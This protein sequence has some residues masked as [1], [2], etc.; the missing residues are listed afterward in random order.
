MTPDTESPDR[1]TMAVDVACVGFG[2]AT[3]G[4]LTRLSRRL[5]DPALPPLE[6]AAAPGM[7]LQVL[8]YER[9]DDVGFGVSGVVTRARAIRAA[10]P[11]LDPAQI[12]MATRVADE[13][14]LYLLDPLGASRRSV[15]LR[16]ADRTL[17]AFHRVDG[18]AFALPWTPGF[19][20]KSDGFV[21]SLGQ[22]MQWMAG[23]GDGHR[24]RADLA[25]D[26]GGLRARRR[27]GQGGARGAPARPGRGPPGPA[28]GELPAG[29][30][31]ARRR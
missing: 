31:R 11:D 8:C 6:S 9:A 28:R 5:A 18:D 1:Q 29:H 12:P 7:P 13:K 15:T 10:F 27:G 19:L 20:H 23:A 21:F 14:V 22:L 16:A 4:F 25:G 26:P 3:A 17:R 30:G 24:D 2:P